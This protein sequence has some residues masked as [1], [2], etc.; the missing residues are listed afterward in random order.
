M[1]DFEGF[2]QEQLEWADATFPDQ[3]VQGKLDH[4]HEELNEAAAHPED[5]MEFADCA[6]LILDANRKAG[7]SVEELLEAMHLKLGINRART[8]KNY[9]HCAEPRL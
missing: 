8:W 4:C 6:M 5:V 3:T 1:I 9:R 2:V 7:H